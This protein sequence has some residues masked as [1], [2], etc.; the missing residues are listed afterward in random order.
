MKLM[1]TYRGAFER[2]EIVETKFDFNSAAR[3]PEGEVET[4]LDEGFA[5]SLGP[6][7]IPWLYISS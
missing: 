2:D 6:S 7:G 1:F 5:R 4:I 3:R